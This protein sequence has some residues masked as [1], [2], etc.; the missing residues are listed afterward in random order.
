MLKAN[1]PYE[2]WQKDFRSTKYF[3]CVCPVHGRLLEE[4]E[5]YLFR[6]HW[7]DVLQFDEDEPDSSGMLCPDPQSEE[8]ECWAYWQC[9]AVELPDPQLPNPSQQELLLIC[10]RIELEQ[11]ERDG[12]LSKYV[13]HA[14]RLEGRFELKLED[15][16]DD[17]E[18]RRKEYP[19]TLPYD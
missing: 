16:Q 8:E 6:Q 13:L 11:M 10:A 5:E 14:L 9:V 19:E 18:H 2:N 15:W 3:L 4:N 12:E 7:Q 1:K 17:L